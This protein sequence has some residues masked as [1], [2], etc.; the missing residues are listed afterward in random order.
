MVAL[1]A[2]GASASASPQERT[3]VGLLRCNIFEPVE[4]EPAD[5]GTAAQ[6][7]HVACAFRLKNGAEETYAGKVQVANPSLEWKRTLWWSVRA[8][9]GTPIVPGLLKQSYVADSRTPAGQIP[10]MI[11]ELSSGVVLQT[12]SD[13]KEGSTS[14]AERSPAAFIVLGVQLDLRT[15]DG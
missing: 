5:A 6:T 10:D 14:A 12:M 13:V 4:T 9:P 8:P 1:A 3:E 11:G 2:A 15:T 7:R